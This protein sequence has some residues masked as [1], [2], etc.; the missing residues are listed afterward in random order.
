MKNIGD[1]NYRKAKK[2]NSR[3]IPFPLS[4]GKKFTEKCK[5]QKQ[6]IKTITTL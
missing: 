2:K 1:K 3:K 6:Q 5:Q 4:N